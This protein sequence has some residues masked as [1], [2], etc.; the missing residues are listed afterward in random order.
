MSKKINRKEIKIILNE[1]KDSIFP[2]LSN[3]F[4]EENFE[5][6]NMLKFKRPYSD[7]EFGYYLAGLIEGDG[8]PHGGGK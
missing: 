3:E 6:S 4:E 7:K 5:I 8:S 2:V 1:E